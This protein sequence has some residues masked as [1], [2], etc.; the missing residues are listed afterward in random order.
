MSPFS[1]AFPGLEGIVQKGR[2]DA[3]RFERPLDVLQAKRSAM[4]EQAEAFEAWV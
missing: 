4:P 2:A 1:K 3:Y